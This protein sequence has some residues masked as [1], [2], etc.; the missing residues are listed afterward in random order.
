[1]PDSVAITPGL[2]A[3]VAVETVS[4]ISTQIVSLGPRITTPY[5]EVQIDFNTLGD[6]VVVAAVAAKYIRLYAFFL[7]V[8][9]AVDVKWGD[10]VAGTYFHKRLQLLGSGASWQLPSTTVPWFTTTLAGSL[11]L[12]LSGNIQ[13]SGR[14]YYIQQA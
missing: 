10:A 8:E 3:S 6:K 11:V 2:G 4:A 14:A 1:M 9:N 13:V 5:T 12:N 7:H